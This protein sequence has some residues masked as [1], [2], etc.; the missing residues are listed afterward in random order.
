SISVSIL[1]Y[2][3]RMA[4]ASRKNR[5]RKNDENEVI[6]IDDD[7]PIEQKPKLGKKESFEVLELREKF[8]ET[9][10]KLNKSEDK[11]QRFCRIAREYE[12]RAE[13]AES[14][15]DSKRGV[16]DAMKNQELEKKVDSLTN[17]LE[18]ERKAASEKITD[19]T[20]LLAE[21]KGKTLKGVEREN[22]LSHEL[23]T[24]RRHVEEY[25]TR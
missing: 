17:Q 20:N 25:L 24:E 2:G 19:L 21:E 4:D 10:E 9:E 22:I 11:F 3:L 7:E 14:Q 23:E 8:R 12:L 13:R 6:I 15:L 18:E 16:L 1:L 5:R